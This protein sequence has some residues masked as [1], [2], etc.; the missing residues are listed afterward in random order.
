[1]YQ[2]A[3]MIAPWLV[4]AGC[5]DMNGVAGTQ[6]A[7]MTQDAAAGQSADAMTYMTM[8]GASDRYEIESS[9]LA[10][11]AASSAEVKRFASM[12]IDHH[13][14]TTAELRTAATKAGLS[15]PPPQLQPKQ[16]EM[17]AQLRG[18]KGAEFD[19]LYLTQQRQAHQE[20]LALHQGYARDGDQP[21]LR[22]VATKA[23]PIIQSH[24]R[25]LDG[26]S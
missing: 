25:A 2:R 9:Q 20:A 17:V 22:Q 18:A 19:R 15:P 8:A 3:L 6:G 16:A 1:M 7:G 14:K 26:L 13:T 21:Q 10:Q 24:I 12:M 5:A 11:N 4:L 23:V